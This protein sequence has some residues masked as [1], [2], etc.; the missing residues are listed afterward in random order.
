MR[1]LTRC[2]S[3]LKQTLGSL[4]A[5]FTALTLIVFLAF[6]LFQAAGIIFSLYTFIYA[7]PIWLLIGLPCYLLLPYPTIAWHP[8]IATVVGSG[9]GLI[10]CALDIIWTLWVDKQFGKAIL[11]YPP[12]MILF[13]GTAIV[14]GATTGLIS[15]F[16]AKRFK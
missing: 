4:I 15:S 2:H 6:I 9:I 1:P 12:C 10:G 5:F 7:V 13:V 11:S 3:F 14:V 8:V 16:T